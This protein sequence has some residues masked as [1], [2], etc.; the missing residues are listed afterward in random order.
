MSILTV[1]LCSTDKSIHKRSLALATS[2]MTKHD[3]HCAAKIA[4]LGLGRIVAGSCSDDDGEL[5]HLCVRCLAAIAEYD[6]ASRPL[7]SNKYDPNLTR[8]INMLD[9]GHDDDDDLIGNVAML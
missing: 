3:R 1:H 6:V 5:N 7:I 4:T 8:L 9:V 2:L